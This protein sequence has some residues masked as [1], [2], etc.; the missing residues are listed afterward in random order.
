[1]HGVI[2][3]LYINILYSLMFF[4]SLN[5]CIYVGLVHICNLGSYSLIF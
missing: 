1:M 5:I 4:S 3:H 2:L